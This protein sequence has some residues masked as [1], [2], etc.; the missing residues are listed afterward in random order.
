MI[1]NINEGITRKV[2][3]TEDHCRLLVEGYKKQEFMSKLKKG[4]FDYDIWQNYDAFIEKVTNKFRNNPA[5]SLE[6]I[7]SKV[8][9]R[10][11]WLKETYGDQCPPEPQV[12]KPKKSVSM[13]MRRLGEGYYDSSIYNKM[14][15]RNPNLAISKYIGIFGFDEK[16]VNTV[17]EAMVGRYQSILTC[18]SNTRQICTSIMEG[19]FDDDIA[20]SD[21]SWFENIDELV[22]YGYIVY[23]LERRIEVGKKQG[24]FRG[25]PRKVN[26][27]PMYNEYNISLKY[28]IYPEQLVKEGN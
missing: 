7:I 28:L 22:Y 21:Y 8:A 9:D 18:I 5:E 19:M 6:S 26:M 17:Y 24:L 11:S 13:F 16:D 25:L 3:I 15:K 20:A 10:A 2:Y 14:H 27:K 1:L 23:F 12:V 4:K